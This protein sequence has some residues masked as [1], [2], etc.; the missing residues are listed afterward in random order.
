MKTRILSAVVLLPLF[1]FVL[2]KGGY[3]LSLFITICFSIGIKEFS[4][5]L[6]DKS[7]KKTEVLVS[8]V[9]V[10]LMIGVFRNSDNFENYVLP[11]IFAVLLIEGGFVVFEKA[12][13]IEAGMSVFM[14]VYIGISMIIIY[15]IS[16]DYIMFFPYIFII[17]MVTD[18]FAYFSGVF[19]GKHKLSPNLSPKKTLEGSIGGIFFCTIASYVYAMKFHTDFLAYTIPFAIIGSIVSQIGDIFASAFKRTM[20]IKDYGNIIPG[21]GGILD[22]ADSIIFTSAYIYIVINFINMYK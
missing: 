9:T 5:A 20:G 19:F 1:I 17:S 16:S 3:Y 15:I 12:S 18:T 2:V 14:F 7:S 13:P 21:H 6:G 10:I 4:D 22:R 11:M 8:A